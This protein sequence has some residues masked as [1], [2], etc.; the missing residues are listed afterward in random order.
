MNNFRWQT[1]LISRSFVLLNLIVIGIVLALAAAIALPDGENG[2]H[3][4]Q[5]A[6]FLWIAII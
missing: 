5:A 3:G 2:A 6:I 4:T 1:R